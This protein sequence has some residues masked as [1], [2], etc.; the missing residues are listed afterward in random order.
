[1]VMCR[2]DALDR[3]FRRWNPSVSSVARRS[4]R[5]ITCVP[6]DPKRCD[7]LATALSLVAMRVSVSSH[8]VASALH[9]ITML[10]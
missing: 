6:A 10:Q 3:E 8:D 2:W 9:C 5:R 7:V 1:M 4:G